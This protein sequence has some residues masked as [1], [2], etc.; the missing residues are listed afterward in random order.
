[1]N[2]PARIEVTSD[3]VDYLRYLLKDFAER[4]AAIY[5]KK[6]YR[7]NGDNARGNV[8]HFADQAREMSADF[9]LI[10][11]VATDIINDEAGVSDDTDI[12]GYI[13]DTMD[14][15]LFEAERRMEDE[16]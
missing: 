7:T 16:A 9:A 14:D 13:K 5:A 4:K 11:K 2:A 1:M 8:P 3:R 10:L 12:A 15:A 6:F